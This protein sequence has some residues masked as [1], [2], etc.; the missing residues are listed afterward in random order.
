MQDLYVES[1]SS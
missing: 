1:I